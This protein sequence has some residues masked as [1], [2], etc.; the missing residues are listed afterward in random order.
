MILR[1]LQ[2]FQ[3]LIVQGQFRTFPPDKI[4]DSSIASVVAAT[5]GNVSIVEKSLLMATREVC[6][7]TANFSNSCLAATAPLQSW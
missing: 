3:N 6:F 5:V 2:I 4:F 7:G 1:L